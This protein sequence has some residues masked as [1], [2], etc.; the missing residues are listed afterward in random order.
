MK[1]SFSTVGCPNF[2]WDEIVA[3]AKDFGYDGIELRGICD[4]LEVYKTFP[5]VGDNLKLTKKRLDDLGLEISCISTSCYLFDKKAK[6][7]TIEVA[8][9]HMRLAKELSC[10]YIRVLGD[11]WITPAK[12]ID[13]EFV[14][15]MLTILCKIAENYNVDVLI[16]TNGVWADSK[17]LAAL[18]EKVPYQNVGVVWDIHHPFR[19]FNEDIEYTYGNLKGYIKHVHVKDSIKEGSKLIFKMIGEG[20]IP[21]EKAINLL[22]KDSYQGYISLEWVKRWFSELEEPGIVFLEFINRIKKLVV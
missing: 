10:K 20:D 19:F 18:L 3:T 11:E 17:K 16:E 21:I 8:E 2:T 4:E 5:F 12:D 6:D 22:L 14:K 13:E 9:K 1:I 15:E 7:V